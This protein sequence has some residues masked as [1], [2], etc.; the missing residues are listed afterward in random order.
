MIERKGPLSSDPRYID[1]ITH[2]TQWICQDNTTT[3]DNLYEKALNY[4]LNYIASHPE[5][6]INKEEMA[7]EV[8]DE[9]EHTLQKK[10]FDNR[11]PA[12]VIA[13]WER[14]KIPEEP[15]NKYIKFDK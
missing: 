3:R 12:S 6:S 9:V 13:Q 10:C 5:L 11:P 2:V 8:A 4:A 1:C 15:E 7:K 14:E